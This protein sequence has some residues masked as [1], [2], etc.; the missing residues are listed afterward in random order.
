MGFR[1]WPHPHSYVPFFI[2]NNFWQSCCMMAGDSLL[3]QVHRTNMESSIACTTPT[4]MMGIWGARVVSEARRPYLSAGC[5]ACGKECLGQ[6]TPFR[7]LYWNLDRVKRSTWL[8]PQVQFRSSAILAHKL[9]EPSAL[10]MQLGVAFCN[11]T[12]APW[13]V[14]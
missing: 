13:C 11:E 6:W 8:L 12:K 5:I 10:C 2:W 1:M 3:S 4:D 7:V 9:D 14:L